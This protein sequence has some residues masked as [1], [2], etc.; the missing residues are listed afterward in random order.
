MQ[1][2]GWCLSLF[3]SARQCKPCQADW[4]P[5]KSSC[6]AI[7]NAE[8]VHQKTWHEAQTNCKEKISDLVVVIDEA[9]KVMRKLGIFFKNSKYFL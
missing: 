7:N 2:I 4:I 1:F 3:F 8:S 9:E 5:F 6:Y